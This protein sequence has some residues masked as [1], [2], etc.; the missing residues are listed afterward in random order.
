ML[1]TKGDVIKLAD[2]G[3]A[4]LIE[5]TAGRTFVGSPAYMSP[6]IFLSLYK[7]NSYSFNTDIW[8]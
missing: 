7:S 8:F 6:E 3:I 2:L 1:L 4:K 5:N